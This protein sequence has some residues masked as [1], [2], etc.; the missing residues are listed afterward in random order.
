MV[1]FTPDFPNP[2]IT[3]RDAGGRLAVPTITAPKTNEGRASPTSTPLTP[4]VSWRRGSPC[5]AS[6]C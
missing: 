5:S 3:E 6:R 1:R 2:S 4:K